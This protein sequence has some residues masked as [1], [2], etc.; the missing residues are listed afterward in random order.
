MTH[1][2]HGSILSAL[3]TPL[4]AD[5]SLELDSLDGLVEHNLR[6]G[7]GGFYV[8]GTTG[9]G[10]S[11]SGSERKLVTE[12]V[13]AS[14]RGRATVIV[15]ISH[16]E[17]P[18]ALELAAHAADSGADMVS[19]LPPIYFPVSKEEILRYYLAILD[20]VR[21]PL[22]LYN[23]PMLSSVTLD[24]ATVQRLAEHPR[25]A[26]IKHSSEDTWLLDRFK[27]VA[28]GRLLVWSARDAYYL[29]GLA[30]GADGGIGSSFNLLGD[31]FV[32]ITEA[33]RAGDV[34][35]AHR[36]QTRTNEV[37]RRL[38]THGAIK[39]I[40]ACLTMLGIPCGPCRMPFGP[41]SEG[42]EPYLRAT[43]ELLEQVRAEQVSAARS[44]ELTPALH[45]E[46][47]RGLAR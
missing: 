21:L 31:L 44:R 39:S 35:G 1:Q 4:R 7:V 27:R 36:T 13:I 15:N 32:S 10:L 8:C 2:T 42:A 12:R 46:K 6:L 18:V 26:G 25:F 3:V 47:S 14:N 29:G 16:M 23:I 17:F 19:T 5:G 38:Q 24:E 20:R 45:A 37:H 40:K 9:E 43:L 41:L 34:K 11:L 22:T 33:Y 30:M 28:D